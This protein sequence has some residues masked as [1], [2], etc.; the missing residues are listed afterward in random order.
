MTDNVDVSRDFLSLLFGTADVALHSI[1]AAIGGGGGGSNVTLA[2]Y[3]ALVKFGSLKMIQTH[4]LNFW[5]RSTCW[6][7]LKQPEERKEGE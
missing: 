7:D 6:I 2:L 4:L 5:T 1:T 3:P